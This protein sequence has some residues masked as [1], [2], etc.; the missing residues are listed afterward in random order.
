MRQRKME[1]L[2][3]KTHRIQKVNSEKGINSNKWIHQEER[4]LKSQKS[5][6]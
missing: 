4:N 3:T 1:T 5:Q 6:K 2:H